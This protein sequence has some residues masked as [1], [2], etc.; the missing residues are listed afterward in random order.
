MTHTDH[1]LTGDET[2]LGFISSIWPGVLD[3]DDTARELMLSAARTQ[4]EA[5]APPVETIP[6]NYRLAQIY[7][8]RA[9]SR[10][11]IV[12]TDGDLIAGTESI[13]IFPMDWTV[14]RLLNPER[15]LGGIA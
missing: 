12:G 14:K 4:C 10:A 9:L 5:Y 3:L 13:T 1:W 6:D 8:A 7:Q 2:E 11:G 15:R